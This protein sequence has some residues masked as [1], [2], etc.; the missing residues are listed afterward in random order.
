MVANALAAYWAFQGWGN[1]P[2]RVGDELGHA[3]AGYVDGATSPDDYEKALW[4]F[5]RWSFVAPTDPPA[6]FLDTRT[7]RR[8]DAPEGGARLIDREGLQQEAALARS[9]GHRPG[10]PMIVV[11]AV[12]V[13]GLEIVERRQRYAVDA[14]G[15]YA[16][17]F[18]AWHSNL[19]GFVDLVRFLLE[20][21]ELPWAVMCSGDVHYGFTVNVTVD[22]EGKALPITQLVSSPLH[23]SGTTSRIALTTLG[24]LSRERHERVGWDHPPALR[25]ERDCAA[26][27]SSGRRTP[28]NGTPTR[29]CSSRRSSRSGSAS[30]TRR[31]T[32]NGATTRRSGRPGRR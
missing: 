6:L 3:I 30:P 8:Y 20:D 18:E 15:P 14:V 1:D 24:I 4:S 12:P 9:A 11:S 28:T 10:Q 29:P 22:A 31:S 21:L 17:D 25:K 5:D 2:E 23:H 16:I 13:C 19:Q 32:A 26:G 27:S 7:Q